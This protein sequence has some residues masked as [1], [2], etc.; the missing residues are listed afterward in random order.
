MQ[1][2]ALDSLMLAE[3]V[4]HQGRVQRGDN[5]DKFMKDQGGTLDKRKSSIGRKQV[6]FTNYGGDGDAMQHITTD[7]AET[8]S[9]DTLLQK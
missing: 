4:R 3:R 5:A 9:P 7:E 1:P 6:F 2:A 8:G